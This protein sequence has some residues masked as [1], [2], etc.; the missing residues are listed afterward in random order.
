MIYPGLRRF[1]PVGHSWRRDSE[2]GSPC[3]LPVYSLNSNTGIRAAAA[4]A[5][6]AYAMGVKR[7]AP[8]D[9]SKGT[10]VFGRAATLEL[11]SFDAADSVS[12]EPMHIQANQGIL[13]SLRL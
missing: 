4:D 5:V 3:T 12:L 10:G 6:Q 7:N 8:D 11:R 9:P 1:L 2:L 13:G